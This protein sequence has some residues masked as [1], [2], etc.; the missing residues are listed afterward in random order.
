MMAIVDVFDAMTHKRVYKEAMPV[1]E[2]LDF[3]RG[4]RGSHFDPDL[5]DLFTS[6]IDSLLEAFDE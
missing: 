6:N 1:T 2:T 5:L 4:Q 3:M